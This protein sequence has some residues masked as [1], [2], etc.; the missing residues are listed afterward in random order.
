MINIFNSFLFPSIP[1]NDF[2]TREM[3]YIIDFG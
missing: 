3:L 2:T 1:L